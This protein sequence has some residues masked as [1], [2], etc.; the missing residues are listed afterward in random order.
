MRISFKKNKK[1]K[2][3]DVDV[4]LE[5]QEKKAL[6]EKAATVLDQVKASSEDFIEKL[7]A[8]KRRWK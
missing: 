1:T 2:K 5:E 4:M 3:T 8:R 6:E 7:K